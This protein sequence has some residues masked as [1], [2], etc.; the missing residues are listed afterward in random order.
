MGFFS[1]SDK[2]DPSVGFIDYGKPKKDGSHNHIYNRGDD[3]TP[4]QKK[5]DQAKKKK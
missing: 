5:A 3:K 2:K 4:A 1:K